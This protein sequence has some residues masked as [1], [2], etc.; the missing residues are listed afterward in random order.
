VLAQALAFLLDAAAS[1]FILAA[2]L[3]FWM[4]AFRAPAR[5]PIAHFSMAITDWAVRPLRRVIPGIAKLDWSSLL[6]AWI[7][8][9]ALQ[10]LLVAILSGVWADNGTALSV[11][12]FRAF[13]E[14]ARLSIYI[15]MGAVLLGAVLSWVNPYHPVAPFFNALAN[16]FMKP[17]RRVIP[18]IGGLDI[19][20][21]FVLVFFQFMLAFPLTWLEQETR[22]MLE[23]ALL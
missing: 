7:L 23:R 4:Q 6:V 8:E 14:L 19:S 1:V 21:I 17:V 3:R 12:L 9:F 13:V 10:Y 11:I 5:N 16:P 15:F 18:P 22:F 2:L 20:P